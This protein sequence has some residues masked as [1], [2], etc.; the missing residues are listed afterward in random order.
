MLVVID[1]QLLYTLLFE[2]I[3]PHIERTEKLQCLLGWE[4]SFCPCDVRREGHLCLWLRQAS[5]S[6]TD[7]LIFSFFVYCGN[8]ESSPSLENRMQM[9]WSHT[10]MKCFRTIVLSLSMA[11]HICVCMCV[12]SYLSLSLRQFNANVFVLRI[13]AKGSPLRSLIK[14]FYNESRKNNSVPM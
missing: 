1:W 14:I 5:C 11:F 2:I 13:K 7:S 10:P 6:G 3:R 4:S 9:I 8:D 12:I